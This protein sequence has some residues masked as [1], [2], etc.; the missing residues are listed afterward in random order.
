[1]T[2]VICYPGLNSALEKIAIKGIIESFI[3]GEI[4]LWTF[5]W[6]NKNM[7]YSLTLRIPVKD[8]EFISNKYTSLTKEV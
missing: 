6:R 7:I 1:M 3:R 2:T 4:V 8:K 5:L